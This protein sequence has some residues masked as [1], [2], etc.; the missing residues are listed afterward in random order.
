MSDLTELKALFWG[1]NQLSSFE[2]CSFSVTCSHKFLPDDS[3]F[4]QHWKLCQFTPNTHKSLNKP[5][6]IGT[7]GRRVYLP[8]TRG[9]FKDLGLRKPSS[10]QSGW[11]ECVVDR[12]A[13][14]ATVMTTSRSSWLKT[15]NSSLWTWNLNLNCVFHS[16]KTGLNLVFWW[17][18]RSV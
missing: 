15:R 8:H 9:K 12:G 1:Q 18:I 5:L 13:V 6:H 4:K 10:L 3:S 14:G 7:C 11:T 2:P 16:M 17:L